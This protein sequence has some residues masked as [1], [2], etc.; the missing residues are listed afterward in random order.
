MQLVTSETGRRRPLRHSLPISASVAPFVREPI[1]DSITF[2]IH[3]RTAL[4]TFV[5]PHPVTLNNGHAWAI[6]APERAVLRQ[7]HPVSG[8]ARRSR[9]SASAIDAIGH[10]DHLIITRRINSVLDVPTALG[11]VS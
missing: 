10:Q 6:D 11:N 4:G 7:H 2:Q 5:T 3:E 8:S 9:L 1:Q